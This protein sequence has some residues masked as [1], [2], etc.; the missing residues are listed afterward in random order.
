M[1]S[2]KS[3]RGWVADAPEPAPFGSLTADD[4]GF[5]TPKILEGAERVGGPTDV[6]AN[7]AVTNFINYNSQDT[8]QGLPPQLTDKSPDDGFTIPPAP[9]RG[10]A[11]SPNTQKSRGSEESGG[12]WLNGYE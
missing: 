9:A 8:G 5:T 1:S 12:G 10:G 3:T 7:A 4:D 6:D 11:I 2:G